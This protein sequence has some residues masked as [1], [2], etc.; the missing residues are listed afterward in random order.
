MLMAAQDQALR[1]R[2][3][4]N[5]IDGQATVSPLCRKC[6]KKIETINHIISECPAL[7]QNEY[8]KR[9]D[10]VA[11]ALHWQ[12]C[13][14]YNMPYS[15]RWY[16]QISEKVVENDRA[17]LLWD[18]DVRTCHRIQARKPDLIVVNKETQKVQLIDVAIPW[19]TRVMEKSRKKKEKYH[20]LKMEIGRIWQAEMEVVPIILGALGLIPDDLKRNLGKVGCT[21]LEPGLLQKCILQATARIVRR[22]M[23]SQEAGFFPDLN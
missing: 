11:K 13:K 22:V 8:K 14:E 2:Y 23:D 15:E 5:R 17:K 6:E 1:T 7:A 4:Q 18:Y 3:I 19:D 21:N 12:I 16:E 9:H 10:T 20:D